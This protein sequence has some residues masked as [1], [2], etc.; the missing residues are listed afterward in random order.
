MLLKIGMY[1]SIVSM[2]LMSFNVHFVFGYAYGILCV[3]VYALKL[4]PGFFWD[5]VWLFFGED[6]LATLIASMLC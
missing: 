2:F 1:Y 3:S 5:K 6:R 4:L